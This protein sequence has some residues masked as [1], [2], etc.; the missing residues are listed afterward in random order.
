MEKFVSKETAVAGIPSNERVKLEGTEF[1]QERFCGQ[2][3]EHQ[4]DGIHLQEGQNNLIQNAKKHKI[5]TVNRRWS[6]QR[7]SK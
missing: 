6:Y 1:E 5:Q 7:Y 2:E 3:S 4:A